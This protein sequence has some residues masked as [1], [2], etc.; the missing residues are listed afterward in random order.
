MEDEVIEEQAET[1]RDYEHDLDRL[2]GPSDA[3]VEPCDHVHSFL[4]ES[5]PLIELM[6]E[7]QVRDPLYERARRWATLVFRWSGDAY[8]RS[9]SKNR[10]L[11]RVH[12][13]ACLVPVKVAFARMDESADDPVAL[14][15]AGKEYDLARRYLTR[16]L[17]SLGRVHDRGIDVELTG[18]F[19]QEGCQ[20]DQALERMCGELTRRRRFGFPSA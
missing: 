12:V 18:K 8:A 15:V 6:R 10:D 2:F 14:E 1:E 13:N 20:L 7:H 16:T 11:F 17:E 9:R 3:H 4:E 5:R 19:L